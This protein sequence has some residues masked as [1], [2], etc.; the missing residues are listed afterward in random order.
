[1]AIVDIFLAFPALVLALALISILAGDQGTTVSSVIVS[2][3]VLAIAPLARIT[4]AT[5]LQFSQREFVTAARSVGASHARILRKE[6]LPNVVPPMLSFALVVLAIVIVAEAALSFVGVGLPND[7]YSTWGN[8]IANGRNSP[9]AL[10]EHGSVA[11]TPAAVLFI[12]VLSLNYIGDKLRQQLRREGER[13]LSARGCA[14]RAG[15]SPRRRHRS[16]EAGHLLVVDDLRTAFRTPLGRVRAV[17]GVSFSLQRGQTLGVV[18]E[19]GSG[20]TVL[21]RTIMGLLPRR[22]V[23]VSGQVT[24]DGPRH[25][26]GQRQGDARRLGHRDGDGLPGPDDVAQPGDARRPPDHRVAAPP[27]R[28][29]QGR[30][31]APPRSR[32]LKSVGIPEA[33]RR[34]DQYPHELSGGMRQRVTIAIALACGP[35]LLFADEPTTALDVTV[36]AQ[37]LDLLAAQQRERHMAMILVTHDLGVVAGSRRRDRGDVRRPDRRAGADAGALPRR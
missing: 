28:H 14:A 31:R 16:S 33:E 25:H 12:T 4:R 15:S 26:R 8:M 23:E 27:P 36:Q 7:K 1:M 30:G 17:D 9:N 19:S 22:N 21:S 11:L 29:V 35:K 32:C 3:S 24:Y 5:T 10:E 20:K 34:L 13:G 37:I 2:L 18:G 6:I